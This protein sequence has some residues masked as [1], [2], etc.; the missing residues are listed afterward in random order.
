MTGSA[1]AAECRSGAPTP[2]IS[3]S[4][5]ALVLTGVVHVKDTST[6]GTMGDEPVEK[7]DYFRYKIEVG[8]TG[9]EEYYEYQQ[10]KTAKEVRA[11]WYSDVK[12]QWGDGLASQFKE[13]IMVT[14]LWKKITPEV[15]SEEWA[16]E[17]K[18]TSK[19]KEAPKGTMENPLVLPL[20]E[21]EEARE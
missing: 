6:L 2:G 5:D 4:V 7:P 3:I 10:H 1:T 18:P 11:D 14:D 13:H 21:E 17:Q 9:I 20:P 19:D 12:E 8:G 16:E 15:N